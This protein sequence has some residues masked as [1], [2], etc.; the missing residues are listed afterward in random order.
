M[1][2]IASSSVAIVHFKRHIALI[3]A[4]DTINVDTNLWPLTVVVG[5]RLAV[6]IFFSSLA[7]WFFL[8][9]VIVAVDNYTKSKR[10][11]KNTIISVEYWWAAYCSMCVCV[12]TY[13]TMN[14]PILTIVLIDMANEWNRSASDHHHLIRWFCHRQT[15]RACN[16]LCATQIKFNNDQNKNATTQIG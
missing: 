1:N 6:S 14:I 16:N 3:F 8:I 10:E 12:V 7:L 15:K 5:C 13:A 4:A 2:D 11:K 9:T